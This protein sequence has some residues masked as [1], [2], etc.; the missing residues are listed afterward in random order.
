MAFSGTDTFVA[1]RDQII[2]DSLINVGAVG[3][4]ETPDG[5]QLAHGSRILND[6]VKS[7]DADGQFLWRV[8]RSTFTTTASDASYTTSD[9]PATILDIDKPMRFTQ[10]SATSSTIIDSMTRDEYMA[11]PNRAETARAPTKFYVQKDL[12]SDGRAQ[13]TVYFWPTPSTTGDTIEF[14]AFTRAEDMTVGTH[15]PDFPQAWIYALKCGLS[16]RLAPAYAQPALARFYEEAFQA[17]K[18]KQLL[19]DNERGDLYFVPYGAYGGGY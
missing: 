9:I 4:N 6:L 8:V 14:A 18:A 5:D 19:N 2:M 17:E 15:N 10:A 7:I 11:I 12:A 3:I 13:I 16:A 1:T